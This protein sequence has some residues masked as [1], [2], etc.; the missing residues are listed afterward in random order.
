MKRWPKEPFLPSVNLQEKSTTTVVLWA[1]PFC[2]FRM[3]YSRKTGKGAIP[4]CASATDGLSLLKEQHPSGFLHYPKMRRNPKYMNL[5]SHYNSALFPALFSCK[6]SNGKIAVSVIFG[7]HKTGTTGNQTAVC[8]CVA[9]QLIQS[10]RKLIYYINILFQEFTA[11]FHT[12]NASLYR[13]CTS[14]LFLFWVVSF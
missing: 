10:Y 6:K 1:S 13:I 3:Q 5:L 2:P 4:V 9:T 7:L 12:Q 11:L 8:T 14:G